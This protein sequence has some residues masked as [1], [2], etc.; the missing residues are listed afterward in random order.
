LAATSST[1]IWSPLGIG[2]EDLEVEL[3]VVHVEGTC[4]LGLPADDLAG[5]GLPHPVHG[6]LLDDHVPAADGG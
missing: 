5:L 2:I 6:D 4:L 3:H 1:V